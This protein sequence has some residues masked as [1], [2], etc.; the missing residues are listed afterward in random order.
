MLQCLYEKL[1][2]KER[3]AFV[4]SLIITALLVKLMLNS[5]L[6]WEVNTPIESTRLLCLNLLANIQTNIMGVSYVLGPNRTHP[7]THGY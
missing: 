6:T 1:F 5:H 3:G 4:D 2:V 7:I